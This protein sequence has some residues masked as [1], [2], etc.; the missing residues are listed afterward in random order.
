MYE[1]VRC[2]KGYLRSVSLQDLLTYRKGVVS[3]EQAGELS[4]V[5]AQDLPQDI[6]TLA[7]YQPSIKKTRWDPHR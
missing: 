3:L 1:N 6:V 2:T 7:F 5:E 4:I